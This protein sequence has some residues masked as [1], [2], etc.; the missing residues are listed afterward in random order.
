MLIVE[1]VALLF[2]T[3]FRSTEVRRSTLLEFDVF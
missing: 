1:G 3:K 2:E